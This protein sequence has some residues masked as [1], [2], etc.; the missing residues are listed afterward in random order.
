MVRIEP[1]NF[2]IFFLASTMMYTKT[3]IKSK[4][5]KSEK[6]AGLIVIGEIVEDVPRMRRMLKIFDPITFPIAISVSFF[7]AAAILVTN[8][9]KEVPIATIVRPTKFSLI[10]N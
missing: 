9:G 1:E 8:S 4:K 5:N 6:T 3:V 10:P 7:I 2:P